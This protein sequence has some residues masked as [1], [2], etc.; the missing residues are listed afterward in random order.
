VTILVFGDVIDDILIRP[1][2]AVTADSDTR[3]EIRRR[4]GGSA[5]NQAAWLGYLGSAV[6]FVGRVGT[7]DV[8]RHT[9]ELVAHGVDV[10]LIPDDSDTGTIVVL[11]AATD[12]RTMF[13]DRG[14]SLRLHRKDIPDAMLRAATHLHLTGYSLFE[15]A[16]RAQTLHILATARTYG[17]PFSIDPSSVAFLREIGRAN[18]RDW[19]RGAL[20][21]FPNLDEAR[22]LTGLDSAAAAA[23]SLTADYP[24]VAVTLGA[25]GVAVAQRGNSAV[26]LPAAPVDCADP[27]G[28]GDAFCAG[29][30]HRWLAGADPIAAAQS[31][32]AVAAQAISRFGARPPSP[33][34][35]AP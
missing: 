31:G 4:P 16:T 5:A 7:P 19:T 10:R 1:L 6:S 22:C 29:F 15:E 30:L 13:A 17:I 14:A 28:A 27:T 8:D 24:I 25:A 26:A 18:F 2:D 20:A 23:E 35:S 21:C 33:D 11:L 12:E 9:R 34:R 3:A 32:T